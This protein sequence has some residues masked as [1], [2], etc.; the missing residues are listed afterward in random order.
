MMCVVCKRESGED[1][2]LGC[3]GWRDGGFICGWLEIELMKDELR[4]VVEAR[5][6]SDR[7]MAVWL[8]FLTG[9]IEA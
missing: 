4:E 3:W 7:V 5:R 6:V 1:W 8:F 9:C 2:V